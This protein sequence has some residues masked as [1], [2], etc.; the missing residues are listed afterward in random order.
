MEQQKRTLTTAQHEIIAD[1]AARMAAAFDAVLA[2][3]AAAGLEFPPGEHG[4]GSFGCR[5]CRC[6][7]FKQPARPS[8]DC[9]TPGCGH[10]F[11]QHFVR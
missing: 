10:S 5:E 8:L 4:E 3:L 11:V 1:G 9:A 7:H 2:D 6:A